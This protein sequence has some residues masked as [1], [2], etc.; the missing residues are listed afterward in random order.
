MGM[1]VPV[2]PMPATSPV[3]LAQVTAFPPKVRVGVPVAVG[4]LFRVTVVP[5][6]TMM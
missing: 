6:M 5:E 1:P 3:V 4:L 2:M